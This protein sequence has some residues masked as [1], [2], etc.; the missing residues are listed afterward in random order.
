MYV[1]DA[2]G[3]PVAGGLRPPVVPGARQLSGQV[4]LPPCRQESGH[5]PGK[6]EAGDCLHHHYITQNW[7]IASEKILFEDENLISLHL[8]VFCGGFFVGGGVGFYL[9]NVKDEEKIRYYL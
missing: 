8:N 2:G 9:G 1:S 6:S 5:R 4:Q 7:F 3:L